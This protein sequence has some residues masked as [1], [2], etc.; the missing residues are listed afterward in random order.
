L[1]GCGFPLTS[2][3]DVCEETKPNWRVP[4]QTFQYPHKL[5][6]DVNCMEHHVSAPKEQPHELKL[7]VLT[8]LAEHDSVV[9]QHVLRHSRFHPRLT[10]VWASAFRKSRFSSHL[11]SVSLSFHTSIVAKP[12]VELV[13]LK[14]QHQ[15]CRSRTTLHIIPT[16][17][18][19][20]LA[21]GITDRLR[22]I[23]SNTCIRTIR[24][25]A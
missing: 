25:S 24:D 19:L 18:A 15:R 21:I 22:D 3:N 10:N 13:R 16:L 7:M 11:A 4:W 17:P 5:Y 9:Q 8:R 12:H 14:I 20:V 23:I 2:S 6:R 1:T